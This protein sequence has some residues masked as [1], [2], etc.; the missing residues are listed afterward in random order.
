VGVY[1]YDTSLGAFSPPIRL[2]MHVS[3][4][5]M[6]VSVTLH[7]LSCFL[8]SMDWQTVPFVGVF[9]GCV[10]LGFFHMLYKLNPN[11]ASPTG[12]PPDEKLMRKPQ[13]KS[14]QI[15]LPPV[16]DKFRFSVGAQVRIHSKGRTTGEP[17]GRQLWMD[18]ES[19]RSS[20]TRKAAA[21]LVREMASAGRAPGF[22][23]ADN[24]NR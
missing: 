1:G 8:S 20:L 17:C 23:P 6:T 19:Q 14:R 9:T 10:Y 16:A 4:W 22:N 7:V 2:A 24:P 3:C 13:W 12:R 11:P 5:M 15:P 18:G 21:V